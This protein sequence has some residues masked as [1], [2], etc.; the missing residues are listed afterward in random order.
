M[1]KMYFIVNLIA[2]KAVIAK[3]L[4]RIIDEFV[5][6]DYEVTVH[7]TQSS[8]DVVKATQYACNS[9][10]DLIVCAGGDGTLS[11][12]LQ[13][14]MRS[15][16]KLPLGYIPAG[17]TNDFAKGLNIP[18]DTMAAVRQIIEG[19]PMPQD[20]GGF[21]DD[22]FTYIVAF[23]AFTSITYETSQQ[24]KNIF[25]HSAYVLNALLQLTNIHATPMKI[26]Y[27]DKVIEDEFVFGMVS[28][29]ASVA[30]L[31]SVNDFKLDDGVFEVLLIKKPANPIQ[32]Q[33]IL[34]SLLNMREDID[35]DYIKFFRTNKI[36]FTCVGDETVSWTRDG[37]FGGDSRE[38]TIFNYNK[39]VSF[40][41]GK[42]GSP[43]LAGED[44]RDFD[45]EYDG[46]Y[47]L[48]Y[49]TEFLN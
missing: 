14:M 29:T 6:A 9:N 44:D 17:T 5:K 42:E 13:A 1:K 7:T 32:L 45:Y 3:K 8:D 21:N 10:F 24:I 40:I 18:K 47:T 26:E 48:D 35:K 30:G 12:C 46:I 31:F 25:G 43:N 39:A 20:V 33:Q 15:E 27:D 23:G 11:N 28:N 36:T 22:Y 38:N 49:D 19:T 41:V 34:H 4:G 16:K 2:G 37:E